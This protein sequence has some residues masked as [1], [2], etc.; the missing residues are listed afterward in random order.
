MKHKDP[1]SKRYRDTCTM[2]TTS[3]NKDKR[4][5]T[6]PFPL[7]HARKIRSGNQQ[8]MESNYCFGGVSFANKTSVFSKSGDEAQIAVGQIR[9]CAARV[10]PCRIKEESEGSSILALVTAGDASEYL[11]GRKTQYIEPGQI[12]LNPRSG[13]T[14]TT[15]YVSGILCEI[16]HNRL[17]KTIGTMRGYGTTWEPQKSCIFQGIKPKRKSKA[18]GLIWKFFSVLDELL[19]ESD[20]LATGLGLDEQIYRLL[21]LLLFEEEGT[22]EKIQE[23]WAVDRSNWTTSLDELVDWIRQNAHLN[24]TL[25]DLEEQRHYSGRHLQNL[26][27]EKF[28]CTPMQ[29]AR[30]Q[31]LSAAMEKLQ[32]ADLDDTVTTIARDMGYRYTSSF[33]C[34]F[35]REFGVLPSVVLRSSRGGG[36]A[37]K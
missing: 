5:E 34:D 11:Q 17:M 23:L 9:I 22:L 37:R 12:H 26:F 36:G 14:V 21:A 33:C 32:T 7:R 25:T 35:K 27:K 3:G 10:A 31:R 20:Y 16:G 19:G 30:R 15:G 28:D 13:G 2:T 1:N 18:T 8:E 6:L 4:L 29:F 24:L